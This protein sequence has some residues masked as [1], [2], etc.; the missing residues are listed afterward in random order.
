[1]GPENDNFFFTSEVR[2]WFRY[3]GSETL[4]FTGD[5]DVWVFINRTLAVDLGGCHVPESAS[6]TLD[7][8][9]AARFGLQ[10]SG[11]YPIHVFHAE[12]KM[13]GSSFKLTLTG[14]DLQRSEC[15]GICGDGIVVAGESCDDGNTRG[16]DECEANCLVPVI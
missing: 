3:E 2:F 9:T 6:V 8:Q 13:E 7:R 1:M 15:S 16:G 5:D 12:R 11:L 14:F 10:D 4:T